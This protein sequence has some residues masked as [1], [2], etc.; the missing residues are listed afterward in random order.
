LVIFVNKLAFA[1]LHVLLLLQTQ[2]LMS[3][4]PYLFI[5]ADY[6]IHALL[7][8]ILEIII[9]DIIDIDE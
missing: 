9:A 5:I 8:L 4:E 3:T 2:S 7:H 6:V 1:F